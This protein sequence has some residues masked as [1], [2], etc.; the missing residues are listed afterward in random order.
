MPLYDFVCRDCGREQEILI[1]GSETPSCES[2]GGPSLA[3]LLS[4]PIAHMGGKSE[5]R[6]AG[7]SAGP[8]GAHCGCHPH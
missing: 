1:R 8:C 5:P 3:K 4:A 6:P 7:G 2:C